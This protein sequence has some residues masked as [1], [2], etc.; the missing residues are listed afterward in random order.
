MKKKN[1][2]IVVSL[3]VCAAFAEIIVMTSRGKEDP[4]IPV[5][6]SQENFQDN[7]SDF[8]NAIVVDEANASVLRREYG[9]ISA[10]DPSRINAAREI[11][12]NL[13]NIEKINACSVKRNIDIERDIKGQT[14]YKAVDRMFGTTDDVKKY[15][16]SFLTDSV[17]SER[18]SGITEGDS[19]CLLDVEGELF[20]KRSNDDENIIALEKD[21][22]GTFAVSLTDEETDSFTIENSVH[23]IKVISVD[24]VWKIASIDWS[25]QIIVALLSISLIAINSLSLVSAAENELLDYQDYI[26][27]RIME[28]ESEE[29]E[30]KYGV[31]FE[32]EIDNTVLKIDFDQETW[33]NLLAQLE[34]RKEIIGNS[35]NRFRTELCTLLFNNLNIEWCTY[36]NLRTGGKYSNVSLPDFGWIDEYE[37]FSVNT[38][39]KLVSVYVDYLDFF[40][41]Y[42]L[43]KNNPKLYFYYGNESSSKV[44]SS[45][46]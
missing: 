26:I 9:G 45:L 33:C 17:I 24:C 36:G 23:S 22:D 34:F 42:S 35:P 27:Q 7:I 8:D 13:D 3:I 29:I 44:I 1:L 16:S 30:K 12:A 6:I 19:P 11:L 20:V 38:E 39:N 4:Q 28:A 14:Y 18:Y 10:S 15:M 21:D 2:I 25:V 41:C 40:L 31:D 32:Q 46:R 5:T 43:E 37:P